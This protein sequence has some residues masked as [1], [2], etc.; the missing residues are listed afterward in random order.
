MSASKLV[1]G[2]C[3]YKTNGSL[4]S[5][6]M[7]T[8]APKE[9]VCRSQNELKVFSSINSKGQPVDKCC[10]EFDIAL[11]PDPSIRPILAP[12][13]YFSPNSNILKRWSLVKAGD[14]LICMANHTMNTVKYPSK[15]EQ[16]AMSCCQPNNV[17]IPPPS[18]APSRF[19][20][21]FNDF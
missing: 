13:C 14:D 18:A 20:A 8:C 12:V 10:C 11:T 9:K 17:T 16:V 6:Y 5:V 21:I 15:D 2:E 1:Y 19:L 3:M 7:D 4:D